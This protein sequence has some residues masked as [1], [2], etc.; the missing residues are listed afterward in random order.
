[1]NPQQLSTLKA[2][3]LAS[4]DAEILA[5]NAARNA[6]DL[7]KKLNAPSTFYVWRIDVPATEFVG[8]IKLANFTPADL[9]PVAAGGETSDELLALIARSQLYNNRCALCELKQNNIRMIL[10]RDVV[11]TQKLS[12]RQDLTDALTNVPAGAG[13]AAIDAGWLGQG[14]TKDTISRLCTVAERA[15]A[16]GNGTAGQPGDLVWKGSVTI[17]DLGQMWNL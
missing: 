10:S 3:I 2:A 6:T 14:K 15:F 16:T 4:Q 8:A 1:M 9:P 7:A 13:G 11:T 12:T 17:D 5:F